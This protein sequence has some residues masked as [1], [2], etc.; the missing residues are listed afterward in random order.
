MKQDFWTYQK[1]L[2]MTGLGGGATSLSNAGVGISVGQDAYTTAG[3]YTWTCPAG[4][5]SVSVVCIGAGGTV[6]TSYGGCAG[7]LAYKNNITV[8]PGQNYTIVVG[9]TNTATTSSGTSLAASTRAGN[10]SAFGTVAEGGMG[11]NSHSYHRSSYS[12][13][14]P[15]PIGTNY[16]GGGSGGLGGTDYYSSSTGYVSGGGGGAGGYSGNGGYGTYG[17]SGGAAGSGGGGG[18]GGAMNGSGGRSA[19]GGGTGIFGQGS[20]GSGGLYSNYQVNTS[21]GGG[22]G[23][24]DGRPAPL[25]NLTNSANQAYGGQYGGASGWHYYNVQTVP[26]DTAAQNGAVRIIYPGTERQFPSTRTADE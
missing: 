15:L 14:S 8:T 26:V 19:G 5:T 10:S 11:G 4:V 6:D 13:P 23:G 2:S 16:D 1:P 22:S 25:S 17:P 20:S 7:S 21:G 3:T 24:G 9:A 18:G 12:N